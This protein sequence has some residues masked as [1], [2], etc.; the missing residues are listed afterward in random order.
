VSA[1]EEIVLRPVIEL[2][3]V[4][5]HYATGKLDVHALRGID[6][7]IQP[8]ELVAIMGPSGSGKTTL[9][10]ILGCLS[11][12]SSGR[13]RMNGRAVDE[14]DADGL[15][16]LRGEEIGFVFQSFNL[17]PRLTVVENVE[18]PL[19]YR[20]VSR[21]D[22]R[23][24]AQASLA[25]VGLA[26]RARHLPT[27]ISGGERQRV[28]I[29]RAL[30]NRPSLLLADEPT[31]NLDSQTGSEILA[32]LRSV[33]TEGNTVVIVTHD[34][35]IGGQTQ[36]QVFLRDGRIERDESGGG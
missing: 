11:R 2:E 16:R 12:P 15:A 9:M 18:L 13:Y 1:A 3:G 24:R 27:E 8:G 7:R 4:H 5:K 30:V 17:L 32:L 26:P 29:A 10:E 33:H 28:A 22:R 23:E 20:G 36:R 31:G 21:T 19:A 35:A 34:A 14:I 25:R 6:L